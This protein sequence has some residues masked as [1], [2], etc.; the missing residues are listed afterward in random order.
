MILM[1]MNEL[2]TIKDEL[3]EDLSLD[4]SINTLARVGTKRLYI[5]AGEYYIFLMKQDYDYNGNPRWVAKCLIRSH[6]IEEET[7]YATSKKTAKKKY[8]SIPLCICNMWFKR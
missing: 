7:A 3:P 5:Y 4:N 6:A 8:C 2:F 1:N